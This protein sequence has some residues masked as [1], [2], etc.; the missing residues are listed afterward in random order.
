MNRK[1][2]TVII[3]L[4]TL[5]LGCTK[6]LAGSSGTSYI[7]KWKGNA[8]A[9]FSI[10]FD[11]NGAMRNIQASI[12]EEYEVRGTFNPITSYMNGE[13]FLDIFHRGHELGSHTVNHLP[14]NEASMETIIYEL[15]ESKLFIEEL[16]G[17]PCVSY[18]APYG[19]LDPNIIGVAKEL[20]ISARGVG[21][22]I[23]GIAGANIFKL[24]IAPYPIPWGSTWKD[25]Q[26]IANLRQ[27][28]EDVLAVEGW[29]IEMW[30]N[31]TSEPNFLSSGQ[32]V[33]ETVFRSHLTELTSGYDQL[34]W[35]APQG[36]VARYWLEWK[37]TTINTWPITDYVI[38]VDLLFDGDK[39]I[40]NEPLTVVTMIPENWLSGELT[41]M[42]NGAHLDYT[43][44]LYVVEPIAK[45]IVSGDISPDATGIYIKLLGDYNGEPAYKHESMEYYI[46]STGK[47]YAYELYYLSPGLGN[48]GYDCWYSGGGASPIGTYHVDEPDAI[49][50]PI[51]T[52]IP[53]EEEPCLLYDALPG[54]G[55][56]SIVLEPIP[57][58]LDVD[59]DVDMLDLARLSAHWLEG[60]EE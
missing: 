31:L 21:L 12:L 34:V 17:K 52:A 27:Y 39:D 13:M 3:V 1:L 30:H 20:Y 15:T 23:N 16:T 36:E 7:A 45:I 48:A 58:D 14:L 35:V 60:V 32:T 56:V 44:D 40:F 22:G 38:L 51:A 18:I 10:T 41:V 6:M 59:G 46:W 50:T 49:G 26:Y 5:S 9:A 43:V 2:L 28:V 53:G 57:G 55:V 37:E 25:E 4:I 8:R 54:A 29:G 33:N 24:R 42:Q 47:Q 19:D 11:D